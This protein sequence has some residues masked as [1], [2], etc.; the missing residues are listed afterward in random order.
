MNPTLSVIY[1]ELVLS[2]YPVLIKS[3]NTNI[4]TQMLSRFIS[5]SILAMIFGSSSFLSIWS[6]PYEAFV[7]ILH[8]LLN[9]CHIGASYIAFKNLHISTAISLF[10]LYPIF[11]IIAGSLL[12]GESVSYISIFLIALSF[13]GTYLIAISYKKH[14][15][16]LFDSFDL[17]NILHMSTNTTGIIM[18]IVA[19]LTETCIFIS[20][21]SKKVSPYY[22]INKLY[23]AGLIGL[24][25][26]GM[27]NRN[28]VDTSSINWAKLLGFNVILGFTGYIARFY[29]IP[30]IPII[31]F[32]ML[33]FFGVTFG[34]LWDLFLTRETATIKALIGSCLI[35]G[36]AAMLRYFN[37]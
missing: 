20:V 18:G 16:N 7:G 15:S 17:S 29:A 12:F 26:Y 9:I 37:N 24:L 31:I 13:I 2:L 22:T 11:N 8:N 14:P 19:A 1:G 21:R 23:P 25:I 30:Q 3:V 4:F 34:Y 10:Y 35:A 32:S 28:I 27:F 33:S 5:F 6:T 36:S